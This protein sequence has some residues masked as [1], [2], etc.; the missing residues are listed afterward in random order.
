[1][2]ALPVHAG[3]RPGQLSSEIKDRSDSVIHIC[4]EGKKKKITENPMLF[5]F[6][7]MLIKHGK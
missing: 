3:R 6:P 4:K 7:P 5:G 2:S 1:L